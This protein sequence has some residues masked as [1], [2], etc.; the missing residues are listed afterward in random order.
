MGGKGGCHSVPRTQTEPN[1]EL[2]LRS[3]GGRGSEG[4]VGLGVVHGMGLGLKPVSGAGP[5]LCELTSP[6]MV[7]P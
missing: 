5:P 3:P 4:V 6:E 7:I 1:A 2:R